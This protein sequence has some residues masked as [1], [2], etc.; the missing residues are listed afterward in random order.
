MAIRTIKEIIDTRGYVIDSRDRAVFQ[1]GDI[2]S[3]FGLSDNDAIEFIVYD[4]NDNQLPQNGF[5]LVRY[6]KLSTPNIRDY[7]LIS[8][9]IKLTQN[10]LPTEYFI[11]VERLLREAGYNNGIFKVQITLINKRLGSEN[12]D[13]RIRISQIS[14][15]RTELKVL[16]LN[17]EGTPQSLLDRFSIIQRGDGF[18]E[19]T[20][21][22]LNAFLDQ[23]NPIN[24]NSDILNRYGENW[25]DR[26]RSD[27]KLSG[28]LENT[29]T[30]IY[31]RFYEAINYEFQNRI[32]DQLDNNYGNPKQTTPSENLSVETILNKCNDILLQ[33]INIVLPEQNVQ[34][35]V[36][37]RITKN[38]SVNDIKRIIQQRVGNEV[39][40]IVLEMSTRTDNGFKT[41]MDKIRNIIQ[42]PTEPP[43]ERVI[44][45]ER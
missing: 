20:E 25:V 44:N 19:D 37:E 43:S 8:D 28:D 26:L 42:I 40:N 5:G 24:V 31:N 29:I 32:S 1:E 12:K 33:T 22:A 39:T 13:D 10:E 14:P 27:F 3:F 34:T 16:P 4:A 2:Q 23:L 45:Y 17:R 35:D 11:D 6:I 36:R 30:D 15:S 18:R 41:E 38:S 9:G 21:I 7:F